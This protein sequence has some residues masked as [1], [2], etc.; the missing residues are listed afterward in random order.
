MYSYLA[1]YWRWLRDYWRLGS[2]KSVG[3]G[4]IHNVMRRHYGH[5]E[6]SLIRM[7]EQSLVLRQVSVAVRTKGRS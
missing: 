4:S 7:R 5:D 6:Y 3:A 1:I 2:V